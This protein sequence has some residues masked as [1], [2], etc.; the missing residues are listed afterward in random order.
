M[1]N[2]SV[3]SCGRVNNK[4]YISSIFDKTGDFQLD[5]SIQEKDSKVDGESII[6]VVEGTF[7]VP[8]GFSRNDRFYPRELWNNQ[9]SNEDI[10]RRLNNSIMYGCIGHSKGPVSEEDLSTGRV[11]HIMDKLWIDEST[12]MGM[13]K[14]YILNTES[15]RN[16]K[17]Y[18]KAG[19]KLK[20]SSR[21]E[22]S[23][24]EGIE[25]DGHPVV[26]S[27]SYNLLTF[28]F[29][30]EPG[31]TETN[32]QLVENYIEEVLIPDCKNGKD[33]SMDEKMLEDLKA[34]KELAE[35]SLKEIQEKHSDELVS[36]N[37]EIKSLTEKLNLAEKKNVAKSRIA[38]VL[39]KKL[40][41][42]F[43]SYKGLG[44]ADNIRKANTLMKSVIEEL[45]SYKALGSKADLQECLRNLVSYSE[46]LGEYRKLGAVANL[47][48]LLAL[49]ENFVTM[50]N[51]DKFISTAK[52]L[53]AKTKTPIEEV[54]KLIK[55][56]GAEKAEKT[57]LE[58]QEKISKKVD[59]VIEVKKPKKV[60]DSML[61]EI[62]AESSSRMFIAE[63]DD[64]EDT[65]K[66]KK[67]SE[68]DEEETDVA[69]TETDVVD[70]ESEEDVE[71]IEETP[72]ERLDTV[73]TTID[74]IQAQVDALEASFERITSED[75]D[76][77]PLDDEELDYDIEIQ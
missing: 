66:K 64:E 33:T 47:K 17:T 34:E 16:L 74:S 44:T 6:G 65:I 21:G 9:L 28:D 69:D 32:P 48:N 38:K 42:V 77:N 10:N 31:F 20:V 45:K 43:E 30:I 22:G 61:D 37:A 50:H 52:I 68:D 14:A 70:T 12:G 73:E 57:L 29:V 60:S 18:L 39:S 25:K 55:S 24:A 75:S 72:E 76:Y 40:T 62:F 26:E 59:E 63:E 58:K 8:D 5:E 49:S 67:N 46:E 2:D 1:K 71:D 23:F 54:A 19:S 56:V 53:S 51:K 11:S 3:E 35:K 27:S 7:F 15:G 36:L 41:S 4:Y 13:G